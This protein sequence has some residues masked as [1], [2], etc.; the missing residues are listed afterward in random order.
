M[1]CG[2]V[3]TQCRRNRADDQ[4]AGQPARERLVS[5]SQWI[6][7]DGG[8]VCP[9]WRFERGFIF[10]QRWRVVVCA[11]E[12]ASFSEGS[13]PEGKLTLSVSANGEIGRASC[14][15]RVEI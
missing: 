9:A 2:M 14:R 15:E 5:P 11:R 8:I 1:V 13:A 3:A 12:A 7:G 10:R 6:L 4:C